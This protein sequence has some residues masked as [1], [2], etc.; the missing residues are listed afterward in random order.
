[1]EATTQCGAERVESLFFFLGTDL[2]SQNN[3][4]F[5]TIPGLLPLLLLLG[6]SLYFSTISLQIPFTGP[7][8]LPESIQG[9]TNLP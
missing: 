3:P 4:S 9:R 8:D 1:M 5:A 7:V 2:L 6:F